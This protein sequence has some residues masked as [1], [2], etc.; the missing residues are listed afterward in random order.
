M[1]SFRHPA[2]KKNV[3]VT[4]LKHTNKFHSVLN[5]KQIQSWIKKNVEILKQTS[6]EIN[7]IR[8]VN[9]RKMHTSIQ[10][11]HIEVDLFI[12][13]NQPNEINCTNSL[14]NLEILTCFSTS[15]AMQSIL[16]DILK[17]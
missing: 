4:T 16:F 7:G 12:R 15:N 5:N 13:P 10:N 9:I 14:S 11:T 17:H 3:L 6:H 1:F 2:K 8:V